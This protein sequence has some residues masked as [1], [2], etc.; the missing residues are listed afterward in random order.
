MHLIAPSFTC[1][2]LL[3]PVILALAA[4]VAVDAGPI[5]TS[6]W[7][8]PSWFASQ[9]GTP[10]FEHE[11]GVLLNAT[12]L[13]YIATSGAYY[14]NYSVNASINSDWVK[15]GSPLF[16]NPSFG[17]RALTFVQPASSRVI[18]AFRGTDLTQD[19]GGICDQCADMLL[20]DGI[21]YEDLPARCQQFNESTLDY[22]TAA[23]AFSNAVQD[24]FPTYSIL[25]TGHSL[26]AGLAA[27]VSSLG[28]LGFFNNIGCAPSNAGAIVF[29]PPGYIGTLSNRTGVDLS[30]LDAK[31]IVALADVWDPVWANCNASYA[32]GVS[33]L[34]CSW[35]VGSPSAECVACDTFEVSS[36]ST[37]CDVCMIQRHIFSHYMSL[38]NVTPNCNPQPRDECASEGCPS[39]GWLCAI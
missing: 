3:A 18:V 2:C 23:L 28:N 36:N 12:K 39:S 27:C 25:F 16:L 13:S 7:F 21:A 33:A 1:V 6:G 8:D 34:V 38:G 10:Y 31:R 14:R 19:L 29:S 22:L 9:A 4:F 26:G 5:A 15:L 32:G 35:L 24:A 37:D 30:L 17:L 11:L 20:W